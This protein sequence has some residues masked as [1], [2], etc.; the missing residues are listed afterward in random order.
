[1]RTMKG[2]GI[3]E[4]REIG[5]YT[6]AAL[7]EASACEGE[8]RAE[9]A[10]ESWWSDLVLPMYDDISDGFAQLEEYRQLQDLATA[11]FDIQA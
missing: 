11:L 10:I 7:R 4:G 8:S 5:I 2:R 3:Y 9:S 1:M 6:G